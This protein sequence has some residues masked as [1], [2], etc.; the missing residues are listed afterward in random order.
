MTTC[1]S[2]RHPALARHAVRADSAIPLSSALPPARDQM[3]GI[4]AH[5]ELPSQCGIL[6]RPDRGIPIYQIAGAYSMALTGALDLAK[7]R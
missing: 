7:L 6:C 3:S 4:P 1:R 5:R 2:D